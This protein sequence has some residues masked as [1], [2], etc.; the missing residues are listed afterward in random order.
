MQIMTE[1]QTFLESTEQCAFKGTNICMSTFNDI[2]HWIEDNQQTCLANAT[3]VTA[4]AKQ[5]QLGHWCFSGLG[6]EHVW[7][8][9]CSNK[10]NGAW[11]PIDRKMTQHP[12]V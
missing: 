3:E 11:D 5:F 8:R 6:Q 7:Y 10:P 1:I 4:Y 9:T 12:T 2:E